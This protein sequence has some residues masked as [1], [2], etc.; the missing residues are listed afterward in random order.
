MT[1]YMGQYPVNPMQ[2]QFPVQ[3]Q[4]PVQGQFPGMVNG[5][6]MP[7][8]ANQYPGMPSYPPQGMM[9]NPYLMQGQQP[10]QFPQVNGT[11]VYPATNM[12]QQQ[13]GGM[14][15]GG[16]YLG[17]TSA[18]SSLPV[19]LQQ[20][21]T[22]SA[23]QSA[24]Q[25]SGASYP[26]W[27]PQVTGVAVNQIEQCLRQ[28]L[29][30][31]LTRL[32]EK[33]G[34]TVFAKYVSGQ[35]L[36]QNFVANLLNQSR[37]VAQVIMLVKHKPTMVESVAAAVEYVIY[38]TLVNELGGINAPSINS[39]EMITGVNL[40]NAWSNYCELVLDQKAYP[41]VIAKV[42]QQYNQTIGA[43]QAVQ[44]QTGVPTQPPQPQQGLAAIVVNPVGEMA[45]PMS[46]LADEAY[47][48]KMEAMQ[49][50]AA[51]AQ[52]QQEMMVNVQNPN[53]PWNTG[54]IETAP[55]MQEQQ[56]TAAQPTYAAPKLYDAYLK[57]VGIHYLD[58]VRHEPRYATLRD[59]TQIQSLFE[60]V[61]LDPMDVDLFY[62]AED[63]YLAD[64]EIHYANKR[65][66][67][68]QRAAV[69]K[70][71]E[72]Q[73][74]AQSVTT[75]PQEQWEA[76]QMYREVAE[77]SHVA[78]NPNQPLQQ[79]E[80]TKP[81]AP[82]VA[83]NSDVPP[84]PVVNQVH[85]QLRRQDQQIFENEAPSGQEILTTRNGAV[86]PRAAVTGDSVDPF[87]HV[88][89]PMYYGAGESLE[90]L[91]P[92]TDPEGVLNDESDDAF[93]QLIHEQEAL[94][95]AKDAAQIE[96]LNQ[97]HG[98]PQSMDEIL[99]TAREMGIPVTE[100]ELRVD[101]L[102]M[103]P[104]SRKRLC[105]DLHIRIVPAFI[106]KQY[107]VTAVTKGSRREIVL[108]KVESVDYLKHET[109]FHDVKRYDSW[110]PATSAQEMFVEHIKAAS[111]KVWAENTFIDMLNEKLA[112]KTNS[113]D[114][115]QALFELVAERPIV[116]IEDLLTNTSTA[117][118]YQSEVF[119]ELTERGVEDV[120]H[121][122]E[123]AI[124]TYKR[125]NTSRIVVT[126]D[127]LE[128]M[129]D[130]TKATSAGAV[131]EALHTLKQNA[132]VPTR[133]IARLLK[134]FNKHV[135][136]KLAVIFANGWGV[137]DA[138][139]DYD[140]LLDALTAAYANM[141]V[142]DLQATLTAIYL[143]AVSVAFY[144]AEDSS[145][146]N[147]TAVVGD[148]ESIT[149]LPF[150]YRDYALTKADDVGYI[151]NEQ[152]PELVKLL[153]AVSGGYSIVKLVTLDNVVMSFTRGGESEFFITSVD[154]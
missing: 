74:A 1:Q 75:N 70:Q 31:R 87:A 21:L 54:L 130:V 90:N 15:V 115:D 44:Q 126:G 66:E 81:V 41:N 107:N 76:Q 9:P 95:A 119:S 134:L 151:D 113:D 148:V 112:G 120:G 111:E 63:Q 3:Q 40:R 11:G 105:R 135:N 56:P 18:Q 91:A 138:L 147:E 35:G 149:L 139:N 38:G 137:T 47:N 60:P 146:V 28:T 86:I 73:L 140:A 45:D 78:S 121:I 123:T 106:K 5:F 10:Y 93:N 30:G 83:P 94:E 124:I 62:R 152:F 20:H 79:P 58:G 46:L 53:D 142:A 99:A 68:T 36:D 19:G 50:Q 129:R 98:N 4:F 16:I 55:V 25:P 71:Q 89:A 80:V 67:D 110:N 143:D 52:A 13:T 145:T 39:H 150:Y 122:T 17:D 82:T 97:Q 22:P 29:G 34:S 77:Q 61:P 14:P 96:A 64:M 109:E 33:V 85:A 84:V 59:G 128:L 42:Q 127:N 43:T 8:V 136:T 24:A 49:A 51:A 27:F 101:Y 2:G 114:R 103:E 144:M 117:D 88:T 100:P 104:S 141:T 12:P 6:G 69:A 116:E 108:E 131:I 125:L 153:D 154:E 65:R 57:V 133:D 37:R 102:N 72:A 32:M 26:A 7:V 132:T 23:Q 48:Q 118:E 92:T